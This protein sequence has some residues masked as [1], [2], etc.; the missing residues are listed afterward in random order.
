MFLM[1][2]G[3]EYRHSREMIAA[4]SIFAVPLQ[5]LTFNNEIENHST[6]DDENGA[7]NS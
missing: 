5:F 6:S 7:K 3:G 1:L 4:L 2:F